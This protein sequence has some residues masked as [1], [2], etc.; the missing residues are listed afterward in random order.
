MKR[1]LILYHAICVILIVVVCIS[2]TVF[3]T[4]QGKVFEDE[5]IVEYTNTITVNYPDTRTDC[6]LMILLPMHYAGKQTVLS[7]VFSLQ[8][9]YIQSNNNRYAVFDLSSNKDSKIIIRCMVKLYR[10][11]FEPGSKPDITIEKLTDSEHAV[12]VGGEQYLEVDSQELQEKAKQ[13]VGRNEI[14]TIEKTYDFVRKHITYK[15]VNHNDNGAVY[16]YRKEKGDCTEYS[17][18]FVTLC[19]INDI[20]ARFVE[21]CTT[22]GSYNLHAWAE[23]YI[24]GHG[25]V[26]FDPTWGD[27]D[28]FTH[29]DSMKNTYIYLSAIRN[30]EKLDYYHFSCIRYIDNPVT[31]SVRY[32]TKVL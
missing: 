8:P 5:V 1:Y 20:P 19:R 17:D 22:I 12:Y 32:K 29:F 2:C 25:W 9:K 31:Y 7:E 11:A 28:I 15:G 21:G 10:S 6:F 27:N 14:E 13:L 30:D 18:L 3:N 23:V 4:I 26:A 16:V 24:D